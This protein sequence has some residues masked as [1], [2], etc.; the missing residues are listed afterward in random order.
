V[1]TA[2]TPTLPII[3][4]IHLISL[5][6]FRFSIQNSAVVDEKCYA[7]HC[8]NAARTAATPTLPT[9]LTFTSFPHTLP[10]LFPHTFFI[11]HSAVVDGRFYAGHCSN[12]VR[13]ATTPTLPIPVL[14]GDPGATSAAVR[15]PAFT[16]AADFLIVQAAPVNAD[17]R[18]DA[19]T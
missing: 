6:C 10:H 12:A 1:R 3:S 19:S 18:S 11:Q 5:H 14:V 7:G 9:Y 16:G 13:T 2:A 17:F 8:L 4:H 15:F